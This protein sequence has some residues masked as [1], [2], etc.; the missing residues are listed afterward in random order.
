MK[1]NT[2]T[3]LLLSLL[4][5]ACAS[6]P[7]PKPEQHTHPKSKAQAKGNQRLPDGA[8]A[9]G[10]TPAPAVST[11]GATYTPVGAGGPT[12]GQPGYQEGGVR[13]SKDPRE[14]PPSTESR[15]YAASSEGRKPVV[16]GIRPRSATD[17]EAWEECE[18]L[19][20]EAVTDPATFSEG[21]AEKLAHLSGLNARC[22]REHAMTACY[23]H[24][25]A[26]TK[27]PQGLF[28]SAADQEEFRDDMGRRREQACKDKD[29]DTEEVIKALI[30]RGHL[31]GWKSANDSRNLNHAFLPEGARPLPD[32]QQANI[33]SHERARKQAEL[34]M[35]TVTTGREKAPLP[36]MTGIFVV[37]PPKALAACWKSA[38][39]CLGGLDT[40]RIPDPVY[41]CLRWTTVRQCG[42]SAL[43]RAN[44]ASAFASP[45][46]VKE[47][48][49]FRQRWGAAPWGTST[50]AMKFGQEFLG[51]HCPKPWDRKWDGY[52]DRMYAECPG[53][54]QSLFKQ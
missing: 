46:A 45:K 1:T 9:R 16:R 54:F 2:P 43:A 38:S 35:R 26:P 30:A 44:A 4:A 22:A 27:D 17:K 10:P 53:R 41:E 25:T 12:T 14:L 29:D 49:A 39:E 40:E 6:A 52:F 19:V 13:R 11:P 47:Q 31:F 3:L 24:L 28:V 34:R 32:W 21:L 33:A 18:R 15:I 50:E 5:A 48:E 7:V 37:M 51:R 23:L 20:L 42:F 8:L 36:D